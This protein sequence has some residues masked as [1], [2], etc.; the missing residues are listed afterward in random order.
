MI[1]FDESRQNTRV[2]DL[3]KKEEEVNYSNSVLNWVEACN[4]EWLKIDVEIACAITPST[5]IFF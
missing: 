5:I 3:Y 2:A 4:G 1:D